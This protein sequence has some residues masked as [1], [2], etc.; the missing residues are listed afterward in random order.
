MRR[1]ARFEH[2]LSRRLGEQFESEPLVTFVGSGDFHHVS[3]AL[4]RRQ[5]RPINLLVID[6]HP[7]W[8]R[9]IPFL[10]CG[11]WLYHAAQLPQ[12]KKIFHVGGDVDFDNNFQ[13]LAPWKLI[14]S[15]KIAVL[16]G[17]RRFSGWR[18]A[19]IG[20]DPLLWKSQTAAPYSLPPGRLKEFL[21]P[22]RKELE[23]RP[24]YISLDKDVMSAQVAPV[25]WDSGHLSVIQTRSVLETFLMAANGTVAGIDVV[26]DWSPVRVQ[27][28]LRRLLHW[29]EH[30]SLQVDSFVSTRTNEQTNLSLLESVDWF[31]RTTSERGSEL[32]VAS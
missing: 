28:I 17:I 19:K 20:N 1:Y 22:Y 25:N 26:G 31:T 9:G 3:L 23:S 29:N 2:T 6:N 24:L 4:I 13:F 10:H 11:T 7:D 16:P 18:W 5:P 12:V 8:M 14:E 32:A 27:G 15:D 21:R 30:P